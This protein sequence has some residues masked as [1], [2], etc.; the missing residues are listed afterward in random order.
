[1]KFLLAFFFML[2][3]VSVSVHAAEYYV[4]AGVTAASSSMINLN[5]SA[6][7][8]NVGVTGYRVYRDGSE[9]TTT[10]QTS[11]SDT[12]LT[13]STEYTYTV[14]AYDAAGNVSAQCN[15]V[16]VITPINKYEGELIQFNVPIALSASGLPT[17]AT[18]INKTF[19]WQ[20]DFASAGSYT[21]TFT[22][23]GGAPV[24]ASITV[25]DVATNV[26]LTNK[27]AWFKNS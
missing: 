3:A 10:T 8:D 7:T 4:R 18:F 19:S 24:S 5:W 20:T 27:P 26:G 16:N 6:I 17:G 13:A 2:L 23:E 9:L 22:P 14:S 15:P 1:M 21:V 12:G 25:S 11:Y